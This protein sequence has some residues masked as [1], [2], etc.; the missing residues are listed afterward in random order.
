MAIGRWNV[1]PE[2]EQK[3]R[4]VRFFANDEQLGH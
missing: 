4:R 1:A 3:D 2:L